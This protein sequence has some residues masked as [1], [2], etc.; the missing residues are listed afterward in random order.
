M[1][2]KDEIRKAMRAERRKV[3]P[4]VRIA[5]S[6][7]VCAGILARKDVKAAVEA[8]LPFAVYLATPDELDLS[9]LI[10]R[11]WDV[12]CTVLAPAWKDGAYELLRYSQDTKLVAGPMGVL[13]PARDAGACADGA[14]G[15]VPK[16][17]V[18]IVPGLAFTRKGARLGYGGGWYD[19]FL[20][21]ATGAMSFGVAYPFQIFDELP[22]EGHDI[23]L[24]DVVVSGEDQ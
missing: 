20:S 23:A 15:E 8:R 21:A 5:A 17:A 2:S 4:S 3:A 24:S 1:L 6:E 22:V 7:S 10:R 19:R 11:L 14:D 18:W 16:P 12:G 9:P 13:E